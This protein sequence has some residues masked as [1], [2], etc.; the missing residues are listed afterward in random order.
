MGAQLDLIL[1][2]AAMLAESA[3]LHLSR[4]QIE[5]MLRGVVDTHLTKLERVAHAAKNSP[6]LGRYHHR[7]VE[8]YW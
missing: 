3:D 4:S 2:D 1:E 7:R 6:G 5:T 8:R